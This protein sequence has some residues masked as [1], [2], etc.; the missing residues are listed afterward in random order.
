VNQEITKVRGS[1]YDD[2]LSLIS[3]TTKIDTNNPEIS[4]TIIIK[5]GYKLTS[6]KWSGTL[7]F[8]ISLEE[9][10]YITS[11]LETESVS[12]GDATYE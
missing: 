11:L 10:E 1:D 6:G 5:D 8:N 3:D 12:N 2:N 4:G 7:D 9:D